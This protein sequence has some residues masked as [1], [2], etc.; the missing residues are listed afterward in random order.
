MHRRRKYIFF[1]FILAVIILVIVTPS[2]EPK[3]DSRID[4]A[5]YLSDYFHSMQ[6]DMLSEIDSTENN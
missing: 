6:A 5:G 4:D 1:V 3:K 2:Q